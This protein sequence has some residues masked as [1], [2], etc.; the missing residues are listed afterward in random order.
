[1]LKT[2]NRPSRSLSHGDVSGDSNT[3]STNSAT[4]GLFGR[5][6]ADV[7]LESGIPAIVEDCI[8]WIEAHALDEEGLFRIPADPK[9]LKKLREMYD[10]APKTHFDLKKEN[11]SPHSVAALL[12]M[13]L[14][15]IPEPLLLYRFYETFIKVASK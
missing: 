11:P 15:E 14:R 9:E 7:I 3:K 8:A 2:K 4:S 1:M 12:K 10:A 5:E 6:L 13:Y